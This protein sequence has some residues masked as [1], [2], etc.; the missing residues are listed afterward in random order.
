MRIFAAIAFVV[1]FVAVAQAQAASRNVSA[2]VNA[3]SDHELITGFNSTVFGSEDP[4]QRHRLDGFRVKKFAGR[5][6]VHVIN[7]SR[8]DRRAAVHRF[9]QKLNRTVRGLNISIT[10]QEKNAG[11]I[12]F[13]VDRGDYKNVIRETMPAHFDTSFLLANDCSAV[14]GGRHGHR[15]D[16]AFVFVV[17]NEGRRNFRHCMIEEIVQSLG[18]VNDDRRLKNSIFNDYSK[19]GSFS[20]FDWF[21]LNM[22]YDKR[23]KAGMTR[24]QVERVLPRV[25]ADARKRLGRLVVK[26]QIS[27]R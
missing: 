9:V 11:M 3:Y 6:R 20:V 13:L 12:V 8:H 23:V 10:K 25:I 18:P 4:T 26:K 15:L 22:L 19:V 1:F 2:I 21:I 27:T 16:R 5:V 24:R 14:T 17:V 7:L